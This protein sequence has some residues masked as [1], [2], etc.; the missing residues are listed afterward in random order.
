LSKAFV[1]D[2]LA[3]AGIACCMRRRRTGPTGILTVA[4]LVAGSLLL[5]IDG[6]RADHGS[7]HA[8]RYGFPTVPD[9]ESQIKNTFGSAC[10]GEANDVHIVALAADNG[11]Y[12]SVRA[13]RRLGPQGGSNA[14]TSVYWH[15]QNQ[16]GASH[17]KSGIYGYN[18]RQISGS[19]KYSTH[20]WGIAID[21]NTAPNH[22]WA[23]H[24]HPP[25]TCTPTS[26]IPT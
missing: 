7:Q 23:R 16:G 25:T 14:L 1:A 11:E 13:H 22:Q 26:A 18:C 12:Y 17:Q 21:T 19:S 3:I 20:A 10:N 8:S 6:A 24:C 5:S 4:L 2:V 15:I 9:G